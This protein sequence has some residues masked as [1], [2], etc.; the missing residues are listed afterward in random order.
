M[1]KAQLVDE[2]IVNSHCT[3]LTDEVVRRIFTGN[4]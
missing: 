4:R 3:V 1:P 2:A